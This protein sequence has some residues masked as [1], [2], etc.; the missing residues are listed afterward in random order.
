[1]VGVKVKVGYKAHC[2]NSETSNSRV[3]GRVTP[4]LNQ[5]WSMA[6]PEISLAVSACSGHQAVLLQHR[7]Q[8]LEGFFANGAGTLW[9][10]T[11]GSSACLIH[12]PW[13]AVL[14]IGT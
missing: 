7:R 12:C 1:M 14:E 2:P 10:F 6:Q 13:Q 11:S 8:R 5:K 3:E 4:E 9:L